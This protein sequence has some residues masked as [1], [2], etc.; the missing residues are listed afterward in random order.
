MFK[1]LL[2]NNNGIIGAL[3]KFDHEVSESAL[4]ES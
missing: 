2:N 4:M 1:T 3:D